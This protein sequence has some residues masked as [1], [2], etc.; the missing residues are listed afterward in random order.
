MAA[1]VWF[2]WSSMGLLFVVPPADSA[3]ALPLDNI[4]LPPGFSISLY[5]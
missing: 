4:K 5:V 3:T 2:L 1:M